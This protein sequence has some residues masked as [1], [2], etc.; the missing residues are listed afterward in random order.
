MRSLSLQYLSKYV[1]KSV[2]N[3]KGKTAMVSIVTIQGKKF[4]FKKYLNNAIDD[5]S[6]MERHI[7]NLFDG[8]GESKYNQMMLFGAFPKY[9]VYDKNTFCGFLMDVI[10]QE[11]YVDNNKDRHLGSFYG[12]K[13]EVNQFSDQQIGQFVKNLGNLIFDLH[14]SGLILGDVLNDQ[15][16]YVLVIDNQLYPYLVDTDSIRKYQE[17]PAKTYHSPNFEPP[18]GDDSPSTKSSDIYKYC[19][20]V[21]RIFSKPEKEYERAGLRIEDPASVSSLQRI[22]NTLGDSFKD[23]VVK[24]LSNNPSQRPRIFDVVQSFSLRTPQKSLIQAFDVF[25]DILIGKMRLGDDYLITDD[26]YV[27][28]TANGTKKIDEFFNLDNCLDPT[29]FHIFQRICDS[30][31]ELNQKKSDEEAVAKVKSLIDKIGKVTYTEECRQNISAA[32]IAFS[33][34][35][36]SQRALVSTDM[37]SKAD[38]EYEALKKRAKPFI[39]PKKGNKRSKGSHVYKE[40]DTVALMKLKNRVDISLGINKW[41]ALFIIAIMTLIHFTSFYKSE[42][43][44]VIFVPQGVYISYYFIGSLPFND[45]HGDWDYNFLLVLFGSV[46]FIVDLMYMMKYIDLLKNL[47]LFKIYVTISYMWIVPIFVFTTLQSLKFQEKNSLLSD[48]EIKTEKIL[49]LGIYAILFIVL[50]VYMLTHL[51]I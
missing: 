18:E 42:F 47:L 21:L 51:N 23:I 5:I 14:E 4:A 38:L 39:S 8:I 40:V 3:K 31:K 33:E 46:K 13:G 27:I 10:P 19:L 11:G 2:D 30:I 36:V 34:L 9:L 28:I 49:S 25:A 1:D 48:E 45:E 24:G 43:Y 35:T 7:C 15:N 6:A 12:I 44:F 37:L 26:N 16:L 17:N 41:F 32:W 29:N 22:K 50:V 20:I